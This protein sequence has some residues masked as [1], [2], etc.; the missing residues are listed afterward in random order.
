M[1]TNTPISTRCRV[2]SFITCDGVHIDPTSNKHTLLGIFSSLRGK[3]FPI[4]HPKM[5]WFLSLSE[6]RKGQH[7]LKMYISD[8]TGELEDKLVIDRDFNA[9]D[10]LHKVNLINDIHRLKF[11]KAKAYSIVIEIDDE[12]IFVDKFPVLNQYEE[13]EKKWGK[14]MKD[15][16]DDDDDYD[17]DDDDDTIF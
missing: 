14:M 9:P 13:L 16:D 4:V 5:T 10:P 8:P 1:N 12:I 15:Y 17:D 7:N 3:Q 11:V 2:N 6:L